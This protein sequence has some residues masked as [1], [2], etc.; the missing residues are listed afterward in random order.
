MGGSNIFGRI[1]VI[2]FKQELTVGVVL[3]P[4]NSGGGGEDRG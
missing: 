4:G 1:D 2:I 3:G